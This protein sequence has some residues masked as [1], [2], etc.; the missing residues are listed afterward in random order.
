MTH[1]G[2]EALDAVQRNVKCY[3]SAGISRRVAA[4]RA[5]SPLKALPWTSAVPALFNLVIHEARTLAESH[6][7]AW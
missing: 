3:V 5:A 6:K 2:G 7:K 4:A 1:R